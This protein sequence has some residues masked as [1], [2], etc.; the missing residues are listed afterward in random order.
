MTDIVSHRGGAL[1]WPENSRIA[2]ENTAKLPV[3]QVEFDVHFSADGHIVVIHDATLDRTT[4]GTGPVA[5]QNW[6][7]LSRLVLRGTGGQ[8]MLLLEEVIE[9]FRPTSLG[10]RI[11]IKPGPGRMPYPGLPRR[12]MEQLCDQKMLER[13]VITSFQLGTV[14]EAVSHATPATHAWLVTPDLQTDLGL[15]AVCAAARAR[16][17]PMLALRSNKLD[18]AVVTTVREAGLEVGGW[19]CNDRATIRRMFDLNVSGFTTDRPDLAL[20]SRE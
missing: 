18:A 12:V 11:E 13:S 17:V 1:L 3:G 2:F 10:L 8:R 14:C 5:A 6:A 15:R 4:D 20:Q 7:D 19:A 9:L 16:D